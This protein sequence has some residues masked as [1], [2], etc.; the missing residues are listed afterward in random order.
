MG[1]TTSK[2][3]T[4][5]TPYTP[6]TSDQWKYDLFCEFI[7]THTEVQPLEEQLPWTMPFI[8]LAAA[9][10]SYL[11]SYKNHNSTV[12]MFHKHVYSMMDMY[13]KNNPSKNIQMWGVSATNPDTQEGYIGLYIHGLRLSKVPVRPKLNPH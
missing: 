10:L 7:E 9:Y 6:E 3:T 4:S 2:Y 12:Y 11:I 1:V 8:Q 13:I 5:G